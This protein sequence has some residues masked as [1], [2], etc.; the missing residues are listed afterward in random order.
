MPLDMMDYTL[1]KSASEMHP[2]IAKYL[3]IVKPIPGKNILLIDAMGASDYWGSNINADWFGADELQH[4]GKDYGYQTFMHYAYPYK[5]HNNEARTKDPSRRYGDK[6]P[7]AVYHEPMHRVQLIV[8]VDSKKA[9]D[10]VE[11][12]D[13][14]QYPDV[15]MACGVAYDQCSICGSVHK[16]RAQYCDHAK[17]QLNQILGNGEQVH[18]INHRPRFHDI[19][20]VLIGAEQASKVL[21][22]VASAN[23]TYDLNRHFSNSLAMLRSVTNKAASIPKIAVIEKEI[24]VEEAEIITDEKIDSIK[25][26][27]STEEAI[28]RHTLKAMSNYP[29]ADILSTLGS[30]CI[31]LRPEEFQYMLLNQFGRGDQADSLANQGTCFDPNCFEETTEIPEGKISPSVVI[32][33]K[34]I[35]PKRSGHY[36]FLVDR[37]YNKQASFTPSVKN[38]MKWPVVAGLYQ[39][40][41]NKVPGSVQK[42]VKEGM[43]ELK[44]YLPAAQTAG[45]ALAGIKLGRMAAEENMSS[46]RYLDPIFGESIGSDPMSM[47]SFN[48]IFKESGVMDILKSPKFYGLGSVPVIYMLSRLAEAKVNN[49]P[50]SASTKDI[51][52]GASPIIS[53]ALGGLG[54]YKGSKGLKSLAGL[55]LDGIKLKIGNFS[56]KYLKKAEVV[57]NII[58]K[59]LNRSN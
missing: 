54:V 1:L 20:F 32:I 47:D 6:V 14:N 12:V 56:N 43:T 53:A 25:A 57:D 15:S 42:M 7:L 35:L 9:G 2:E 11:R 55:G 34:D 4:E 39:G 44:P 8:I 58:W 18:L 23:N 49:D 38:F 31:D 36:P 24:P 45:M 17:Y 28:P 27:K 19:S 50:E 3:R 5:H 46:E 22:K 26:L 30:A 10:I 48:D 51:L 59:R 29:M 16:T 13:N 40:Y 21:L 33:I 41:L 52:L 37:M